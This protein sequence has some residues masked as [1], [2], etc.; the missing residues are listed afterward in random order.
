MIFISA[1]LGLYTT[2]LEFHQLSVYRL[3]AALTPRNYTCLTINDIL[4][5]HSATY[6]SNTSLLKGLKLQKVFPCIN[7]LRRGVSLY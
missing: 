6:I 4:N 7:T 3:A 1:S 5:E 2:I